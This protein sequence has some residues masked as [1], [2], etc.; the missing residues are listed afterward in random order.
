MA[1]FLDEPP[2]GDTL[3]RITGRNGEE[4]RLG[5]R[6]IYIHYGDGMADSRLKIPAAKAGTARN[7][8]TVAR[9][10]AMAAEA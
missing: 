1:I 10:A 3:E 9:L 4:V 7:I 2:I 6:E 5:R 8:N